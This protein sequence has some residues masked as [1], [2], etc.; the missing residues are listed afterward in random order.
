MPDNLQKTKNETKFCIKISTVSG[1]LCQTEKSGNWVRDL[2]LDK[3]GE[4]VLVDH[5][6][7]LQIVSHS[8][9]LAVGH[10]IEKMDNA[11]KKVETI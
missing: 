9:A 11:D 8:L 6:A 3:T 5:K 4:V 2:G 7:K 1:P 10:A